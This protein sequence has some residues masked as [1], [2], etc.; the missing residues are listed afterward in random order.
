MR[1]CET[2]RIQFGLRLVRLWT[3]GSAKPLP[4]AVPSST[5]HFHKFSED[6]EDHRLWL[7]LW[8]WLSDGEMG[9]GK[10]HHARDSGVCMRHLVMLPPTTYHGQ[11]NAGCTAPAASGRR[12]APLMPGIE[13]ASAS[14]SASAQTTNSSNN[15][16]TIGA[17]TR[18]KRH[19]V[20][21]ACANCRKRKEKCD[22]RRPT[23]GA[24]ARRGVACNNGSKNDAG[25]AL[26]TTLKSRNAALL[27][28][29][30]RLRDL[31]DALRAVPPSDGHDILARLRAADDP[32]RALRAIQERPISPSL[33]L[34][35]PSPSPSPD[36]VLDPRLERL[37]LLA[38]RESSIR[39]D[40]MPWTAVAS[41]GLVSEL[42]SSFFTWDDAF[43]LPIV[44]R[45]AFLADMRSGNVANA[46]YCSPFLVNAICASRCAFSSLSRRDLA[47]E[48]LNEAKKLLDMENGR[49]SVCAV[50]GLALLFSVSA[51]RGTDRAGILYRFAAYEMFNRLDVE[52]TYNAMRYDKTKELDRRI[53]SRLAWGL[54]CF[55]SAHSF[56]PVRAREEHQVQSNCVSGNL[57]I[58][59]YVYLE[60]SMIPPPAIPRH[61]ERPFEPPG[62]APPPNVDMF[63]N[64]HTSESKSPPFVPGALYLACDVTSM[65]YSSMQW[66]QESESFC[67]EEE[68]LKVRRRKL[69]EVRRWRERLPLNMREDINF[70]PQTCYLSAYTN[71]VLISILRP[72]HPLTEIEPGWTVKALSLNYCKVDIDNMERFVRVYT[73]RDYACI[74]ICGVYN[75]I[76][77]L[78]FHMADPAVHAL[79]AKASW[80]ILQT[81]RDFP[82][83]RYILQGIKAMSW[84]LKVALPPTARPYY[85]NLGSKKEA[86]RDIPI[87]FALPEQNHVRRMLADASVQKGRGEDMGTLLSKWSA[88][89]IE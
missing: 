42:I 25:S 51:C 65:L 45:E 40:A 55:E 2:P 60:I 6:A 82:M 44:D 14:A 3:L 15:T 73:L 24:C 19:Q 85:E 81:G 47:V 52:A 68:D 8:L 29:N 18:Y 61:F 76:L 34:L 48:F 9:I 13:S 53:L 22:D 35:S 20:A 64:V 84:S 28:E 32:V 43:Y 75:S 70:T 58:V 17:A 74:N 16:N 49:A 87:S 1:E 4:V 41:D 59:A 37:D 67:G 57:S 27:H 39:V 89:S 78:V 26:T 54:F 66:N 36:P 69:D 72:L 80:L 79:F 77:I 50:Q 56:G 83:S 5:K 62:L 21:A 33:S 86:F 38:L 46:R 63:G 88:M 23:C 7:W 11:S 10:Y 71:E 31:F 30:E 12:L